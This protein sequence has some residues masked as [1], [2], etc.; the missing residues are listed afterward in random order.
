MRTREGIRKKIPQSSRA[1]FAV[2]MIKMRFNATKH[3]LVWLKY[4]AAF[5]A[6]ILHR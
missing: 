1:M 5:K 3:Y 2:N 4:D 6:G